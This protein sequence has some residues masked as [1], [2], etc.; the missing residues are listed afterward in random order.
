VRIVRHP[1]GSLAIGRTAPGRGAW[2]HAGTPDCLD[3]ALR[4]KAFGRAFRAPISDGAPES[5]RV[6]LAEHARIGSCDM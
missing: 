6:L 3:L 1:D 2:L 5:L 4:R